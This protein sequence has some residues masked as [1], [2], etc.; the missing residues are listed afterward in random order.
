MGV[1]TAIERHTNQ[2]EANKPTLGPTL[3]IKARCRR[4]KLQK[5]MPDVP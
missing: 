2:K 5:D 3:L 1:S 4:K